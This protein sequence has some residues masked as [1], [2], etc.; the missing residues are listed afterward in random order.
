MHIYMH[1]HMQIYLYQHLIKKREKE[2][3]GHFND[4]KV[5]IE[6]SNN[7]QDVYKIERI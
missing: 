7:M 4:P 2:R 5:F 1:M 3:L 6:Y